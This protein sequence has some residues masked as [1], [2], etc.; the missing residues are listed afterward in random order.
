MTFY[1]KMPISRYHKKTFFRILIYFMMCTLNISAHA[2]QV[3]VA[4]ASS[5]SA[6]MKKLSA[7]FEQ[8]TG[9]TVRLSFGATGMLYAQI[10]NGAPYDVFLAADM[11]TP[12]RLEKEGNAVSGTRFTYA[13]GNLVLWSAQRNLVDANGDIL[14]TGNFKHL[15]LASPKL[16]PYGAAAIETMTKLGLIE[17]LQA[18]FVQGDNLSQTFSFI[19]TGN[20]ELGFIALSQIYA[21]GK[22]KSGSAWIIPAHL[23][24][25]IRQ[26]AVQLSRAKDNKAATAL[27]EYL[28][29]KK[30]KVIISSFGYAL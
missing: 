7:D 24:S 2:E 26:D 19:D 23:H 4:V 30:V 5:F 25:P 22:I 6:P 27:I 29:T 11:D 20:A 21:N 9:H 16:A 3:S 14:K 1:K 10:K 8:S 12:A 13:I 17:A 28:Q 18:K 15:A